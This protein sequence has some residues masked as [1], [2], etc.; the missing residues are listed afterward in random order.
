MRDGLP[1]EPTWSMYRSQDMKRD[2]NAQRLR[3]MRNRPA[4]AGR[5]QQRVRGGGIRERLAQASRRQHSIG[6]IAFVNEQQVDISCERY[7]LK[8]IVEH[9]DSD[10][11]I[12]FGVLATL[13]TVS[14]HEDGS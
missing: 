12:A 13:E 8:P 5:D 9:V 6:E 3:D 4:F 7:M 10:V 14:A 2:R 1:A 11:E